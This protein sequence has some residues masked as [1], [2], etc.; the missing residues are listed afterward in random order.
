MQSDRQQ[1]AT[2]EADRVEF[3]DQQKLSVYKGNV[4]FIQ[5][6]TKIHAEQMTL[7][8]RDGQLNRLRIEGKPAKFSQL[9]DDGNPVDASSALM[10]YHT[11][12]GLLKLRGNAQLTRPGESI[13]SEQIDYNS[14]DKTVLANS[15]NKEGQKNRR[16]KIILLPNK[17]NTPSTP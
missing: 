3:D 12:S 10:H 6:S 1:P 2:I 11:D 8:N 16:V 13:Q 17:T 7:Y 14:K 15:G 9:D 4:I 5:G